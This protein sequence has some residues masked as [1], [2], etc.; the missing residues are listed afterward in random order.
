MQRLLL[1]GR[2][3]LRLRSVGLVGDGVEGRGGMIH[4][5]DDAPVDVVELADVLL[6]GEGLVGVGSAL[7]HGYVIWGCH[8]GSGGSRG[9]EC[10]DEM[11]MVTS[12]FKWFSSCSR[13]YSPAGSGFRRCGN[14]VDEN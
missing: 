8:C 2:V 12:K 14:G 10:F 6:D 7:A 11:S 13:H 9:E 5:L 4:E 3:G 1:R